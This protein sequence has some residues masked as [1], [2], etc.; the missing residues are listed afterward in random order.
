MP[1]AFSF[2][3]NFHVKGYSLFC[4]IEGMEEECQHDYQESLFLHS[5]Y[6]WYLLLV[7]LFCHAANL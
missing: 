5:L 7:L 2:T 4:D 6:K 3:A 1:I